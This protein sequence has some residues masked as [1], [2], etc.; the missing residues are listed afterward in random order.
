MLTGAALQLADAVLEFD[1]ADAADARKLAVDELMP[2]LH[3]IL[4][5]AEGKRADEKPPRQPQPAT[6]A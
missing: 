2:P 5:A 6:A 3:R 4:L 1:V